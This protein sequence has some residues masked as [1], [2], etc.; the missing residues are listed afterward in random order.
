MA[1]INDHGYIIYPERVWNEL[2]YHN[3]Q[4]YLN[5]SFFIKVSLAIA[6]G[7]A[8]LVLKFESDKNV[9]KLLLEKLL[10]AGVCIDYIYSFWTSI[11]IIMHVNSKIIRY[12]QANK[13][14]ITEM[15]KWEEFW[16]IVVI[17]IITTI[18][19]IIFLNS[20][21]LFP[22]GDLIMLLLIAIEVKIW[23]Y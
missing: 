7:L 12:G 22:F 21:W 16:M 13:A 8:F 4:I 1:K 5:F 11:A 20:Y 9:D 19:G 10:F 3:E 17:W 14:D 18:I 6:A 23:F 2:K 15:V